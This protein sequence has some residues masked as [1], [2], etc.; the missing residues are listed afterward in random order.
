VDEGRT[1]GVVAH[2]IATVEGT[3]TG[4]FRELSTGEQASLH[5]SAEATDRTNA[6]HTREFATVGKAETLDLLRANGTSV[7]DAIAALD[8]AQLEQGA[9]IFGG[10]ELRVAQVIELALIGHFRGHL[11]NIRASFAA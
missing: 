4:F 10:H 3:I 6:E 11:A 8:D 9:G 5:L 1:V 7:A 2:H